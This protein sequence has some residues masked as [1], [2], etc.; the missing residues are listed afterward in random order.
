VHCDFI[1]PAVVR[2]G[3]LQIAVSTGGRSPALARWVREDL[4]RRLPAEYGALLAL[5]AD[6]RQELRRA[7]VTVPPE[8]WQ[9]AVDDEVLARLRAGDPA[10]ARRRLRA[11]LLPAPAHPGPLSEA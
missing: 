5:V 7:G 10:G 8:R 6:L 2:R 11:A 4:E 1:L 9:R 3:D